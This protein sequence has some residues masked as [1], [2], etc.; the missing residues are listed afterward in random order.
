MR[1]YDGLN[2]IRLV[3]DHKDDIFTGNRF[4]RFNN[5]ENHS[6][7]H[8]FMEDFGPGRPHPRAEPGCQDDH[9]NVGFFPVLALELIRH[10][11]WILIKKG[12][13]L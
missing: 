10:N 8:E 3:P 4:R 12:R 6:P 2:R 9:G 13:A 5:I 7:A 11:R 1:G